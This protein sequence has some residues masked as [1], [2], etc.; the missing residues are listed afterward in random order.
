MG[1]EKLTSN[2]L[3]FNVSL[4]HRHSI[5]LS[6]A[7]SC[8][9]WLNTKSTNILGVITIPNNLDVSPHYI[10]IYIYIYDMDLR[11]AINI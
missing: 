8:I 4:E 3:N 9:R 6:W 10:Y 7:G 5:K 1:W 2:G 11:T